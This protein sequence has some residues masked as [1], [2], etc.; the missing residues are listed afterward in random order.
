[1]K[2]RV[3]RHVVKQVFYPFFLYIQVCMTKN[4]MQVLS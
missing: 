2:R 4:I 3:P 1:M